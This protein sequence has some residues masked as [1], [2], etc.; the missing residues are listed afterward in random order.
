MNY[1]EI[2]LK[3]IDSLC[4]YTNKVSPNDFNNKYQVLHKFNGLK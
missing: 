2:N 4:V 3:F 1:N